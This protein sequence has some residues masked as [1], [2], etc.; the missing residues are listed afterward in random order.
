MYWI[1]TNADLSGT[2]DSHYVWSYAKQNIMNIIICPLQKG[3]SHIS[4]GL[5]SVKYNN[6]IAVSV[7]AG[8]THLGLAY[9]FAAVT[10]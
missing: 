2:T 4:V 5:Q 1:L 10:I 7:Q 3:S 8:I 6:Y 9:H